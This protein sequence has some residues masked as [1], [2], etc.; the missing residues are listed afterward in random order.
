MAMKKVEPFQM[1]EYKEGRQARLNRLTK[2]D[3]PYRN[4]RYK[5]HLWLAGF[6]DTDIK[7][8]KSY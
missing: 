5:K 2:H 3:C 1:P 4:S 8:N 7:M 6:I